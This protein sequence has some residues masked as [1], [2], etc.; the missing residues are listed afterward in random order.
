[1]TQGRPASPRWLIPPVYFA[2]ALALMGFFHVAAPVARVIF[3]PYRYAGLVIAALAIAFGAWAAWTLHRAGTPLHPF[4]EPRALVTAGPYQHSRNPM[5]L[6]MAGTLLGAALYLGSITPFLVLPAFMAVIT[7]R[8]I[9][10]EEQRLRA[11]FGAAYE[12][13][14]A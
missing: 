9:R 3:V 12:A 13:Y 2:V 14:Q 8:F 4:D 6:A 11:A 7:D 10:D 5:Y 1:M